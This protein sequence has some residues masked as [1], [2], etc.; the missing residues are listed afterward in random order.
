[1][2]TTTKY[3]K[4]SA[5][6]TQQGSLA[7]QPLDLAIAPS[8]RPMDAVEANVVSPTFQGS[9]PSP[10]DCVAPT[11]T[12]VDLLDL[13]SPQAAPA[14]TPSPL[15]RLVGVQTLPRRAVDSQESLCPSMATVAPSVDAV[16]VVATPVAAIEPSSLQAAP[17]VASSSLSSPIASLVDAQ[18]LPRRAVDPHGSS[19]LSTGDLAPAAPPVAAPGLSVTPGAASIPSPPLG[20]SRPSPSPN[21][22]HVIRRMTMGQ[23]SGGPFRPQAR[24][25]GPSHPFV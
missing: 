3:L 5:K 9:N 13:P 18:S 25:V 16:A 6:L 8:S 23:V 22:P 15:A 14:L 4:P 21:S 2:P 12:L 10:V 17:A 7:A 11:A 1:M 20:S 19:G 24:S